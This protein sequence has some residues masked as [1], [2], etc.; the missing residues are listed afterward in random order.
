[1]DLEPGLEEGA[2][3]AEADDVVHVEVAEE[4][5]DPRRPG[6]EAPEAVDAGAGVA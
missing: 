1:M 5:V 6:P 4:D 2:E 3:E